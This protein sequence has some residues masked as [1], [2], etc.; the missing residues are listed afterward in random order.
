MQLYIPNTLISE[1][2]ISRVNITQNLPMITNAWV[3]HHCV[4]KLW[5]LL[6][7]NIY[8]WQII[9]SSNY[10]PN[11]HPRFIDICFL[12]KFFFSMFWPRRNWGHTRQRMS[13]WCG[14][15]P[16]KDEHFYNYATDDGT[17]ALSHK[18][19]HLYY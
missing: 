14:P 3:I 12:A 9:V 6:L 4:H 11:Q 16:M 5:Y 13:K 1:M 15:R 19:N 10:D 7:T 2:A 17:K 8:K 18:N